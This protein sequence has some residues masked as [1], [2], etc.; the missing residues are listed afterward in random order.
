MKPTMKTWK[1]I[2]FAA[3][4]MLIA[5]VACQK[6]SSVNTAETLQV[7]LTDGPA[8]YDAVNIDI[9]AVEA[10]IDSC[11][12]HR[13]DDRHGDQDGDQD[14]H[15]RRHDDFGDWVSLSATPGIYD[16]LKLRN[17]ID[18]LLAT[19][20]VNGTIRKIR[21]TL[22]SNN[23]ITKN[24]VTYPLVLSNETA[25]YLYVH[26]RNEHRHHDSASR[27]G[28]WVDFDISR[29]IVEANGVFYL[30]PALRPFCDQNFAGLEG[31]V[32]PA[33]ADAIVKVYN[34][35]DTAIAIPNPDGR[36][37]VRGL[38]A[39]TY[40]VLFDGNNGYSDQTISN[41]VLQTGKSVHLN[42]VTL[43]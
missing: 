17:G 16:V 43:Q 28:V 5:L 4:F 20:S 1:T 31:R 24:G 25:N 21:I 39:G 38:P 41:V 15:Q 42:D 10:K 36:F 40:N 33:A 22:G 18:T 37:R 26:L 19:G 27:V 6:G 14:D 23:T 30:K 11:A 13:G 2:W 35:T 29:S 7:F 9:T 8:D 34:S 3:A 32:L 12:A